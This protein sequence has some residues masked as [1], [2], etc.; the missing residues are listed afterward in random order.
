M[1]HEIQCHRVT[2]LPLE[3]QQLTS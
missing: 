1:K 3:W 2:E